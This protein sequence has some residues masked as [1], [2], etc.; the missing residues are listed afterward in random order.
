MKQLNTIMI[1]PSTSLK[2]AMVRLNEVSEKVLFVVDTHQKLLGSLTDGDIR[3]AIIQ[4]TDFSEPVEKIM[5]PK[6]Q[7]LVKNS[8]QIALKAKAIMLTHDIE[9]VPV[10]DEHKSI[11]EFLY[12]DDVVSGASSASLALPTQQSTP[13]VIMAGGKGTRLDPLTKILPKPLIP[14]GEKP[15]IEIIMNNF[16]KFGFHNFH[17]VLNYKKELIKA[18]FHEDQTEPLPNFIEE[19]KFFG[20]AGGLRLLKDTLKETFFVTNCDIIINADMAKIFEWHQQEKALLTL[21]ASHHEMTIPYGLIEC[22]AAGFQKIIEKPTMDMI[23]N[24]GAYV[25]EPEV[26]D[27]IQPDEYLDMNNL[28]SR[29]AEKHGKEKISVFPIYQSWFDM[30]Q[31]K[32]YQDTLKK[33]EEIS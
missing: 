4:G 8:P 27:M 6:P 12:W 3:R 19:T 29:I 15:M 30:G 18:Y 28:I 9:I 25:L 20:T 16:R 7:F 10:V 26:L 31:F 5:W 13:V 21:V 33:L 17:L 22:D 14:L 24:T 23:V 2:A 1:A 32:E 11:C